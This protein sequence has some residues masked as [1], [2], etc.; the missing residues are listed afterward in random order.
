MINRFLAFG[1]LFAASLLGTF[2]AHAFRDVSENAKLY[3][4]VQNLVE[5]GLMKDGGFFRPDTS[6][7]AQIFWEIVIRDSG[8]DPNSATF[9]TPLPKNVDENDPL[10]PYLREAIRRGFLNPK[11]PFDPQKPINRITAIRILLQINGIAEPRANSANFRAKVS[12][13]S[14]RASYL[15][16]VEAAFASGFLQSSDLRPLRPYGL[17]TRRDFATW[18][19]RF[20]ENGQKKSTIDAPDF[21]RTKLRTPTSS[22]KKPAVLEIKLDSGSATAEVRQSG[23]L[24]IP[25]GRIFEDIFRQIQT[26]YRFVDELDEEA[27][28][29]MIDAAIRGMVAEM[30]DK[31]STYIEP[32]KVDDFREN[33]EGKFEG[34]G[35]YVEMVDQK[36]TITAP[37]VGS[38]A[39]SAGILAGDVVTAVNGDSIEGKSIQESI[40]LVKGPAGTKVDLTILRGPEK[41]EISVIR[42]K[43]TIPAITL[44]WESSVPIIGIHQ[45]NRSTRADFAAKLETILAKNPRGIVLDLRNNPGGFLTS[46]V[47]MGE[48][49]LNRGQEIFSVQ[50]RDNRETFT[51]SR[52]GE[53]ADYDGKIVFLQN[54]GSASASEI[55]GSVLKDYQKAT[56]IGTPSLGK[57]TVQEVQNYSNGGILKLTVAKWLTPNGNWI[58][59][60]GVIPD[61]EVADPTPEQKKRKIDPQLERAVREVLDS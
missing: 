56:I 15:P 7:P 30:G 51:A 61:I 54:K 1:V 20:D 32:S 27:R 55:L 11:I 4:A 52:D 25:N 43:I 9:D 22:G 3:P 41:V 53:L 23:G 19:W 49:F 10:A 6:V 31:Y 13:I 39:E 34:I 57:G 35:A 58:N 59:E 29:A 60:T 8:F 28:Q 16:A 12:G 18:I 26:R 17:L 37:I 42:G 36:F 21:S 40:D 46:A 44:K 47:Q 33:L 50:Y 48:F 24:R 2:S 5:K 14:S 45:F 38:P